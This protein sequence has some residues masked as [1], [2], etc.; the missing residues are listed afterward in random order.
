MMKIEKMDNPI[1]KGD[2]KMKKSFTLIE[3]LVVIAIIAIL[4]AMLLPAL[5]AARERARSASC[6]NKL[7]QIGLAQQ[8]YS[9][10]NKDRLVTYVLTNGGSVLSRDCT[11][12]KDNTKRADGMAGLPNRL[13]VGGFMGENPSVLT[14][15]S[16]QAEHG[17]HCPSDSMSFDVVANAGYTQYNTSYVY[18]FY[19]RLATP[20]GQTVPDSATYREIIGLD[21]PGLVITHDFTGTG[22]VG[23]G[24]GSNHP[25]GLNTLYLGGHVQGHPD[26][27]TNLQYYSNGWGRVAEKYDE[28]RE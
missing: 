8:M 9:L 3:L 5:S 16:G 27:T 10:I 2:L 18:L 12:Y 13:I 17:F 1:K 11:Y 28:G 23:P 24:K 4:A 15:L 20:V 25:A 6:I 26:T 22:G 14:D 21:A 19:N 7:K